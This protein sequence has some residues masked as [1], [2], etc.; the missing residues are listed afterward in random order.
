MCFDTKLTIAFDH[1]IVESPS[2]DSVN[3][4]S[5]WSW[6]ILYKTLTVWRKPFNGEDMKHPINGKVR[7]YYVCNS[8]EFKKVSV[9]LRKLKHLS[10]WQCHDL[11]SC[12]RLWPLNR[13][14]MICARIPVYRFPFGSKFLRVSGHMINCLLTEFGWGRTGKYLALGHVAR[15]SLC[16][17]HSI[18]K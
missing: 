5:Y 18:N 12:A 7:S 10:S 1:V 13:Q 14:K 16:S 15:P 8:I 6:N 2:P 11:S 4:L 17:Y 3:N 9:S